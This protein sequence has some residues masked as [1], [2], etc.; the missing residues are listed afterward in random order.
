M[1]LEVILLIVFI[2]LAVNVFSIVAPPNKYNAPL[3]CPEI[4]SS[5]LL[6]CIESI[7]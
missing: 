4:E 5:V 1:E 6:I 7:K 3:L 2:L